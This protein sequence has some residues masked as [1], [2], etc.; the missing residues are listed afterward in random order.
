[1]WLLYVILP[2]FQANY[3]AGSLVTVFNAVM[4]QTDDAAIF[5]CDS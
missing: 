1:M 3:E 2:P 4:G 5:R